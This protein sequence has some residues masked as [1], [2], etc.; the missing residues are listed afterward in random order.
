M[1][2]Q[3]ISLNMGNWQPT[4]ERQHKSLEVALPMFVLIYIE[5]IKQNTIIKTENL[6]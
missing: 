3:D 2:E 4:Q 1:S 5:R 6:V